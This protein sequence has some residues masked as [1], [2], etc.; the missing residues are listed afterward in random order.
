MRTIVFLYLLV[1]APV[2]AGE[3][4]RIA[5]A[6]NFKPT[7]QKITEPFL[8]N[9]GI[10]VTYSSASSGALTTQIINGA[11]YDIFFAADSETTKTILAAPGHEQDQIFCYARGSLVLAGGNGKLS[12]LA[13]PNLS[14]AIA[15]PATAPYGRAAREVLARPEFSAGEGRKLVRGNSAAQAYQFWEGGSVKMALLPRALVLTGATPIP[16]DWHGP[17]DQHAIVLRQNASVDAYL[18]WLRSDAVRA[19]IIA[20]GYDP[21]P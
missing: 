1:A 20:A 21:C 3:P 8:A 2:W 5:V 12:A 13:N 18:H 15:N 7:L 14:L 16:S 11:P 10:V 4:I 6:A 9:S 17:L 19:Q